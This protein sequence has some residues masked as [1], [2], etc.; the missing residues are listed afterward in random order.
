M[1]NTI[2]SL[3]SE[4]SLIES[5]LAHL[6]VDIADLADFIDESTAEAH[7]LSS[8]LDKTVEISRRENQRLRDLVKGW[9]DGGRADELVREN[10][11]K[12]RQLSEAVSSL[13]KVV[14]SRLNAI[15]R[16]EAF[17]RDLRLGMFEVGFY[18]WKQSVGIPALSSCESG[19]DGFVVCLKSSQGRL[20]T[21]AS[22][23]L[24]SIFT[25]SVMPGRVVLFTECGDLV[26][27][28]VRVF[29]KYGLEISHTDAEMHCPELVMASQ[30]FP[31]AVIVTADD[32]AFYPKDWFAKL[33]ASVGRDPSKIHVHRAHEMRLTDDGSLRP[34]RQW[35]M[36][37][38]NNETPNELIFPTAIAGVAY[39]PGSLGELTV[40]GHNAIEALGDCDDV[41]LW[42]MAQLAGA[43][44]AVIKDGYTMPIRTQHLNDRACEA[45]S[46]ITRHDE[47]VAAVFARFPKLVEI[48]GFNGARPQTR[49]R[50][51]TGEYAPHVLR[52]DRSGA[53]FSVA[54]R[55][56]R[57]DEQL[58]GAEGRSLIETAK[59][60]TLKV[61]TVGLGPA[62]LIDHTLVP[63]EGVWQVW[64]LVSRDGQTGA[65]RVLVDGPSLIPASQRLAP[66]AFRRP[67]TTQTLTFVRRAGLPA[68]VGRRLHMSVTN[69]SSRAL[70]NTRTEIR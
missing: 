55:L 36:A 51:Q 26:P 10:A 29:Q 69:H 41:W 39:P 38:A 21:M 47:Q 14:T 19:S 57:D 35:R 13:D 43:Q 1:R 64:A 34:Y 16:I 56:Y 12:V 33:K 15:G 62:I 67:T 45:D 30:M 46:L 48:C 53:G 24:W 49:T 28:N 54:L 25:Q 60:V 23:T 20:A 4:I 59:R 3:A 22:R 31:Q 17:T 2:R 18:A 70:R 6:K 11:A 65:H 9:D 42:A 44:Y 68:R 58:V 40:V 27:D 5:E 8:S 32:A 50:T 52:I 61:T 7:R 37:A 66:L 63:E